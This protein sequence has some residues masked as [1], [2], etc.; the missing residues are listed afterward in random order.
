MPA[1]FA[2]PRISVCLVAAP[3]VSAGVLNGLFE[4]FAL[5]GMGWE[6]VTGWP[7]GPRSMIPKVVAEGRAPFRNVVGLPISPDLSFVEALRADIV[8]VPDLALGREDDPRG[9]WPEATAWLRRQHAQGA[10]I[11]SVCTG[12]LMLAEAGLLEGEEATCHWSATE[13]DPRLLS[14]R[15]PAPGAGAGAGGRRAPAGHLGRLGVV[16]RPRALPDRA[17]LRRGGGA[18][19]RQGV[20]VRRPQRR[21]AAFRGAGAAAPARRRGD[22]RGAGLD[23][24]QLRPGRTRWRR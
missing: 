10:L 5:V 13:T 18:A 2:P 8:I 1:I 11:C 15:A 20:P 14:R 4:V 21:A 22:R 16:V 3:E 23:R 12:S 7:Q 6:F 17:V 19:H 9:R 24:G